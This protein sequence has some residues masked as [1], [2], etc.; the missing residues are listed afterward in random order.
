MSRYLLYLFSAIFHPLL[1]PLFGLYLL[2]NSGIFMVYIPFELKKSIYITIILSTIVLPLLFIP[3]L[4]FFKLINN[5]Q[6]E[7]KRERVFPLIIAAVL[8]FLTYYWFKHYA[9]SMIFQSFML[10]ISIITFIL[11]IIS[12]FW[13]VSLHMAGIG[14]LT[15]LIFIMSFQLEQHY[16]M[17]IIFV[18][19]ISG[20]LGTVRLLMGAHKPPQ[21]YAGYFLGLITVLILTRF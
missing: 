20:I 8:Y 18:I 21:I 11:F 6:M 3:F 10:S 2:F 15:G 12:F 17:A 7:E 16:L 4:R 1:M 13:K 14:G 5:L 9:F 19:A